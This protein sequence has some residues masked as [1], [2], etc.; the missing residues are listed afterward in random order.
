MIVGIVSR[1][2]VTG[3]FAIVDGWHVPTVEIRGVGKPT[4]RDREQYQGLLRVARAAA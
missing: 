2:S 1:V 3:A 4:V